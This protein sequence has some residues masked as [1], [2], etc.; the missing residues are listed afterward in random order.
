MDCAFL[1]GSI[2]GVVGTLAGVWLTHRLSTNE[3]R[4]IDKARKAMLKSML[5]DTPEGVEWREL[6]TLSRVIGADRD[7][8]TRLLIAVGAR[9]SEKDNDVWALISK[10]PLRGAE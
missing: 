6:S 10:K 3:K 9:G 4:Q 2:S 7:E 1:L 8:T 5:E